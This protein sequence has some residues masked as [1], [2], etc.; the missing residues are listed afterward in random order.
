MSI[1]TFNALIGGMP[2]ATSGKALP[3]AGK[4]L[5]GFFATAER[6]N[7]MDG[8]PALKF[9]TDINGLRAIAVLM[10]MLYHFGVPG[11][12]G[13]F[14]G[15]DVFFVIS[16]FLMTAILVGRHAGG[17]LS[18]R[19][20]YLDRARRILPAL[21]VLLF[22]LLGL[23]WFFLTPLD[24]AGL[25]QEAAAAATF[26]SNIL[27]KGQEGYFDLP[28]KSKWLLHTWSLAV[29][30]QF[31]LLFPLFALWVLRKPGEARLRRAF[32]I[33]VV[34]SLALSVLAPAKSSFAFYLLPTRIWELMA[35]GLVCLAG[36][37]P[38]RNARKARFWGYAGLAL[39]FGGMLAVDAQTPWP[40]WPALVPVMG[41][42]LVLLAARD[43][44]PVLSSSGMQTVG[45][46]SY[47][48]YLWHW[49]VVVALALFAPD[50]GWMGGVVGIAVSFGLGGLS[51]RFVEMPTQAWLRRRSRRGV[52]AVL[53]AATAMVGGCGWAVFSA[54]GLPARVP[55][56]VRLMEEAI[57]PQSLL[58][59]GQVCGYDRKKDTLVPCVIPGTSSGQMILWGDS[60]AGTLLPG[61]MAATGRTVL[62]YSYTCATLFDTELTSKRSGHNCKRFNDK[63]LEQVDALPEEVPV[64]IVNRFSL[65]A[66]GGN[67]EAGGQ[68]GIE[69]LDVP[70]AEV[71]RDPDGVYRRVMRES[72]C[73]IS[74]RRDVFVVRPVPEMGVDVPRA[75]SRQLMVHGR[76]ADVRL[77]MGDYADRHALVNGA[78]DDAA[79]SCPRVRVVDPVPLLCRDGWCDGSRDGRPLYLDDDHLNPE[80][81]RLL[82]PMF[83][84]VGD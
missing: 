39:V 79:A 37:Q 24:Y 82:V 72:L 12:S 66:M 28:S 4:F 65:Y 5:I 64:V 15:V 14:A 61:L 2:V 83:A 20:F 23:G 13:G 18:L 41:S 33:V 75:M 68:R 52:A 71:R 57:K 31:Y 77:S 38:V 32:W 34:G 76:A 78:L 11:F 74:E 43:P 51:F 73:R 46:W 40:S 70:E 84:P 55:E 9:R 53:L 35:G 54:D 47:S 59:E 22:L 8:K 7:G 16:G 19:D 56:A 36:L 30:W 48:L 45:K 69:Y 80:G 6:K 1:Q 50:A 49:P 62:F 29:E 67:E 25:G 81:S 42:V 26:V 17:R 63:V 60:H 44:F 3:L 10:V 21:L 58:P 27:F